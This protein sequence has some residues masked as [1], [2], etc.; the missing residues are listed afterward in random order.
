M[1]LYYF[2]ENWSEIK[3]RR[4]KKRDKERFK[5]R[6]LGQGVTTGACGSDNWQQVPSSVTCQQVMNTQVNEIAGGD[7]KTCS[8]TGQTVARIG[9][10]WRSNILTTVHVFSVVAFIWPQST[11]CQE[12]L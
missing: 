3:R 9:A 4:S 5:Q 8:Q 11:S 12:N 10:I 2:K 1:L 7:Q 6:E